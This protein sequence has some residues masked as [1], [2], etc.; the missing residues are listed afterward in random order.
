MQREIARTK[1]WCKRRYLNN[2]AMGNY[3]HYDLI[4][5]TDKLV[6]EMGE[7]CAVKGWYENWFAPCTA[8]DFGR[9]RRMLISAWARDLG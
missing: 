4:G 5:Y 1:A 9:V 7:N 8:S 2:G 6:R 3:L